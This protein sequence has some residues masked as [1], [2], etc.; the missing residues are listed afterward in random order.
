M[1]VLLYDILASTR[2]QLKARIR[3]NSSSN[4]PIP[5]GDMYRLNTT[6]L[7]RAFGVMMNAAARSAIAVIVVARRAIILSV[8]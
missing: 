2:M 6:I 7:I 3:S 8:L 5:L 4:S 1:A